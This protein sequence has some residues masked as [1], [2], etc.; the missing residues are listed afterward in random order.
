MT[1][2]FEVL[3]AVA[4]LS[5]ASKKLFDETMEKFKKGS[6][7]FGGLI[8]SLAMIEDTPEN[9]KAQ[10]AEFKDEKPP[11]T[12]V[13]TLDYMLDF[14]AKAK[15]ARCTADFGNTIAR[16]DLVFEGRT[17]MTAVPVLVL[18]HMANDLGELKKLFDN[19]PTLQAGID[20]QPDSSVAMR[21]AMKSPEVVNT[22][23]QKT[24][25]WVVVT[26][27]TATQQ[28]I[29][30]DR[31]VD[32]VIGS[33][34]TVTRSGAMTTQQKADA[35]TKIDALILACNQARNR[36]NE[37]EVTNFAF[38]TVIVNELKSTFA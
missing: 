10:S 21:G 37:V 33:Y 20:W 32:K 30:K 9:Q 27:S 34:S 19:A 14:W 12:V 28:A 25:E 18:E 5:K 23:T 15:D 6:H 4:T 2:Q 1:K 35:L 26:P 22:K 29:V 38:A 13:E 3:P 16:A 8:R 11:T 17:L 7:Y 24:T 31:P 36:A